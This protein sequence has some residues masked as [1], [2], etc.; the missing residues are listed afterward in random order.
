MNVM[1]ESSK[2]KG[3]D[4]IHHHSDVRATSSAMVMDPYSIELCMEA[5]NMFDDIS[6]ASYNACLERF[7]NRDWRVMFMKMSHDRRK[8]WLDAIR[9]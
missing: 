1:S 4:H 9:G 8:G 6:Q 2:A 5:L 7:I 3:A